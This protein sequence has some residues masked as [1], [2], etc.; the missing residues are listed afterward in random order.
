MMVERG[1]E[2]GIEKVFV[3][4][5]AITRCVSSEVASIL[6]PCVLEVVRILSP[7]GR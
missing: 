3:A 4:V 2:F 7:F 1:T 5:S 6:R